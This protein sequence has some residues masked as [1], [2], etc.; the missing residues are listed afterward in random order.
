MKRSLLLIYS[1]AIIA[2]IAAC[3]SGGGG[4]SER[5]STVE[6]FASYEEELYTADAELGVDT[7]DPPNGI[8]DSFP[9]TD[10]DVI[11]TVNSTAYS[12]LPEGVD[13]SA[14]NIL[15]YTVS[16]IPQTAFTPDFP[17]K[18][19]NHQFTIPAPGLLGSVVV[20]VPIRIFDVS[21]KN[22]I[23]FTYG[24]GEFKWSVKV[25]LKMEE[26]ATGI[27]ETVEFKFPLRY[28]NALTDTCTYP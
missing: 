23:N 19:I 17:A 15:R 2:L 24:T 21:D 5:F 9:V 18:R 14:V 22:F 13:P 6:V 12:P 1:V 4:G 28:F 25:S 8:C 7:S 11:A 27:G 16:Y 3:D 26:V 10:D 20:E